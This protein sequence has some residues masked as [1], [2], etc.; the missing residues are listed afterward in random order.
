MN[1]HLEELTSFLDENAR[2]H[3]IVVASS[4]NPVFRFFLTS[5]H[6]ITDGTALGVTYD[7]RHR[8]AVVEAHSRILRAIETGDRAAAHDAMERHMAEFSR[9]IEKYYPRVM[10]RPIRWEEVTG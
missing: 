2:F 7:Q 6:R 8:K 4:G 5:L 1:K 9:Y 10:D 3:D